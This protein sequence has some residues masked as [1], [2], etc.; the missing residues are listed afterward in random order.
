[1]YIFRIPSD[2]ISCLTLCCGVMCSIKTT[3]SFSKLL[4]IVCAF[5]YYFKAF[6]P[7]FICQFSLSMSA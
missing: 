1:M 6:M 2:L 5:I 4:H 3:V 7:A